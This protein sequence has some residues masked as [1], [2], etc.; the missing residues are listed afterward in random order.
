AD[1]AHVVVEVGQCGA[2]LCPQP[3]RF[4]L[5]QPGRRDADELE[6]IRQ[7]VG[8]LAQV[9]A[10]DLSVQRPDSVCRT[11]D[12]FS[13]LVFECRLT[14]SMSRRIACGL[15][16]VGVYEPR[17]AAKSRKSTIF[18]RELQARTTGGNR[19]VRDWGFTR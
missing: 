3:D 15:E 16:R 11:H 5:A 19:A 17:I 8:D 18:E 7:V 6:V 10:R 13:L 1:V 14:G 9:S 12:L 4:G 2:D